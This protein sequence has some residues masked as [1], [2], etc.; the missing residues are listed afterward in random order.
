M[1]HFK[2]WLMI[3]PSNLAL[4]TNSRGLP[5]RTRGSKSWLLNPIRSSLHLASFNW[6][7]SMLACLERSSTASWSLPW[8]LLGVCP[9]SKISSENRYCVNHEAK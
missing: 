9:A 4:V 3:M 6:N 2:S 8:S 5:F 7:P 1:F